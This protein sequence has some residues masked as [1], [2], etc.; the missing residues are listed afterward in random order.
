MLLGFSKNCLLAP[1]ALHKVVDSESRSDPTQ[2][3]RAEVAKT[4]RHGKRGD[5]ELESEAITSL[6]LDRRRRGKLRRGQVLETEAIANLKVETG[7]KGQVA[8]WQGS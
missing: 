1:V 3:Q 5:Y 7:S 2:G 6:K 8:T 4:R